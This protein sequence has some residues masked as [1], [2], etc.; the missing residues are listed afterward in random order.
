MINVTP[1]SFYIMDFIV[2]A[3]TIV[4]VL[5][6]LKLSAKEKG[7]PGFIPAV[8]VFVTISAITAGIYSDTYSRNAASTIHEDTFPLG[9][10][11]AVFTVVTDENNKVIEYSDILVKNSSGETLYSEYVHP[12]H[13]YY[14]NTHLPGILKKID[15]K[16]HLEAGSSS[17]GSP[18]QLMQY[19]N[20][21]FTVHN[22]LRHAAKTA[23]PLLVIHLVIRLIK[24]RKR[25]KM[26][27]NRMN[28]ES[29]R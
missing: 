2:I 12:G 8:I 4:I 15:E 20:I 21:T 24:R 11:T 9:N 17:V 6:Q 10:N 3:A 1:V 25:I 14:G 22:V 28:I 26:E 29:L 13:D 5:L 19:D 23:L 18:E 16:Y 7:W 27:M